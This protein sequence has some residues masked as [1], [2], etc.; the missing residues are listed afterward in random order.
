MDEAAVAGLDFIGD[1]GFETAEGFLGEGDGVADDNDNRTGFDVVGDVLPVGGFVLRGESLVG[2]KGFLG[3]ELVGDSD[4]LGVAISGGDFGDER[5]GRRG[6]AFRGTC[7]GDE[8]GAADG[9]EG[10]GENDDGG[11]SFEEVAYESV[12][13]GRHVGVVGVDFVDDDDLSCEGEVAECGEAC[14]E[15]GEKRLIDGAGAE[16]GEKLTAGGGEPA[17]GFLGVVVF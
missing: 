17:E 8:F 10:G 7:G 9:G 14:G 16:G 1:E 15:D 12:N 13:Q 5:V 3:W 11:A 6:F 2:N 4:V